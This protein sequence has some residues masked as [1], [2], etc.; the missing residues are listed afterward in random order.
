LFIPT[1]LLKELV[2]KFNC[3]KKTHPRNNSPRRTGQALNPSLS[4]EDGNTKK[5]RDFFRKEW[6]CQK[7]ELNSPFSS[8]KKGLGMSSC[9]CK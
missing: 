4:R 3:K 7:T 1:P 9:V 2:Q 6:L 5:E 8:Q